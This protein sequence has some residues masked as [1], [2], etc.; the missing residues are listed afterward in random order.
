MYLLNKTR[1]RLLYYLF[2]QKC[3]VRY[4]FGDILSIYTKV[5]IIIDLDIEKLQQSCFDAF[6]IAASKKGERYFHT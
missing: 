6:Q 5:W 3:P 1:N 2:I 4:D